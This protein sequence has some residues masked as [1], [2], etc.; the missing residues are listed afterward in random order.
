MGRIGDIT[1][2]VCKPLI[3]GNSKPFYKYLRN[4]KK[5]LHPI[6]KLRQQ[7]G[8]L[9]ADNS[10]CAGILNLYFQQQFCQD[11]NLDGLTPMPAHLA[12][13]DIH[14]GGIKTLIANLKNNK[15]K[16]AIVSPIHKKGSKE[17]ACNYRPISLTSIPCKMMEHIVLH[18]LN[19]T[20]DN[21][22]HNRQHGFR[23]G[24]S[25]EKQLCATYHELAKAAE[26]ST[27]VHAVILDFQKAFDKVW[28][29]DFLSDRFQK[30]AVRG[31]E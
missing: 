9:T 15:W 17:E 25:C 16:L 6:T 28:V 10:K 1:N 19:D 11:E 7:D 8:S 4:K 31:A 3:N 12:C 22:L 30:V 14:E 24:L 27:T 29:Q 20:L 21:L 18:Y 13:I 5:E 26:Q 23:K 2:K